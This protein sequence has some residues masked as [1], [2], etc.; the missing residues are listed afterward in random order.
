MIIDI[1]NYFEGIKL[2]A[3]SDVDIKFQ[4]GDL[5][6]PDE[7]YIDVY[8]IAFED[9]IGNDVHINDIKNNPD[10]YGFDDSFSEYF[11]LDDLREK[12]EAVAIQ[13]YDRV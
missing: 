10:K 4:R 7:Y 8:D 2:Q 3:E 13:E 12:F 5:E 1:D 11:F 6:T 9:E